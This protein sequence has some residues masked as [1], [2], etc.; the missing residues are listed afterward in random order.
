MIVVWVGH[1][2]GASGGTP[3]SC[4]C[5]GAAGRR[6]QDHDIHLVPPTA[7]YSWSG[8]PPARGLWSPLVCREFDAEPRG[9]R[10]E[11][12]RRARRHGTGATAELLPTLA[13]GSLVVLRSGGHDAGPV[14]VLSTILAS[15]VSWR[16]RGVPLTRVTGGT[17]RRCGFV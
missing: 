4:Q 7:Q 6:E 12:P 14:P 10:D 17:Q 5:L 8:R 2:S 1:L 13:L 15:R 3:R 11:A 16:Q 9:P